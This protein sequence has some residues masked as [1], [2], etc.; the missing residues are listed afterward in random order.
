VRSELVALGAFIIVLGSSL[1][2]PASNL[3]YSTGSLLIGFGIGGYLHARGRYALGYIS[4]GL[5]A[6][7]AA[8]AT[9]TFGVRAIELAKLHSYPLI[10]GVLLNS[11]RVLGPRA[12]PLF[13]GTSALTIAVS[14]AHYLESLGL[15]EFNP[16]LLYAGVGVF[17]SSALSM[18]KFS[19]WRR[20]GEFFAE[21]T[22]SFGIIGGA[23]GTW[24]LHSRYL[25]HLSPALLT[26]TLIIA[27]L[28]LGKGGVEREPRGGRNA[29]PEVE[30]TEGA[31]EAFVNRGDS[32][33]LI[34]TIASTL[35]R[36]NVD[37]DKIADVVRLI[38]RHKEARPPLFAPGAVHKLYELEN[39]RRR[40]QLAERLMAELKKY[41]RK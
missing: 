16:T 10:L 29:D 39:R 41:T 3:A 4:M 31:I 13:A 19:R 7:V 6:C 2:Y 1:E 30:V 9:P 34:A 32:A 25:P 26:A 36:A 14:L 35:A 21:R 24:G 38:L 20:V 15:P 33:K 11:L 40:R 5:G 28:L 12:E 8:Y 22:A 27:I 37:E 23:L 18:L 17:S